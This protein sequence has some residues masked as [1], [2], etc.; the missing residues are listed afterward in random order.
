MEAAW[1]SD[2]GQARPRMRA[3][4]RRPL[5]RNSGSVDQSK[6]LLGSHHD[7]LDTVKLEG[8]RGEHDLHLAADRSDDLDVGVS[9]DGASDVGKLLRVDRVS[10]ESLGAELK[11]ST[12]RGKIT[13]SRDGASERDDGSDLLLEE[14]DQSLEDA[15]T[16][17]RVTAVV[18]V[19]LSASRE[20]MKSS[21]RLTETA[22]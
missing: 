14:A 17:S 8:L 18:E 12:H 10:V 5:T 13:R 19:V 15:E 22:S 3:I 16:D 4:P 1:R 7:L 2:G 9:S 20:S 11:P 21:T 6:S